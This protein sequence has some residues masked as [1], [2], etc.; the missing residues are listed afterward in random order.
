MQFALRTIRRISQRGVRLSSNVAPAPVEGV[1]WSS[2]GFNLNTKDT[3][4]CLN[5]VPAESDFTI[6][7]NKIVP[8]G[9]LSLEPAATVINYGQAVFEGLKAVRRDDGK[10]ACFR[11]DRNAA[12][13]ASGCKHYV[14]PI[15]APDVFLDAVD[16][17]IRANAHW[18]PPNGQGAFYLRPVVFGSGAELGVAPSREF[19]MVIF[20]SPVGSYFKANDGIKLLVSNR[21]RAAP[22]GVGHLKAAGNYAQVFGEQKSAKSQGYNDVLFLDSENK[23]I[24]EVAAS[25][26]FCVVDGVLKT[27][28]L[29][30]CLPGITRESIIQVAQDEGIPVEECKLSLDDVRHASEAFCAGTAAVVT[31]I[32]SIAEVD[33]HQT[34]FSA[35]NEGLREKIRNKIL[36]IQRGQSPDKYDWIHTVEF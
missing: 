5:V 18:V 14:M 19:T 17:V 12:R 16:K 7:N 2:F 15:P 4:M 20:G 8:Y 9:A 35:S 32:S 26:F 34:T 27:P 21:D 28:E 31:R 3:K 30:T 1:D 13:V 23:F 29:G 11:P 33:G 6:A 10:I 24:D 25:N 36:D 22:H